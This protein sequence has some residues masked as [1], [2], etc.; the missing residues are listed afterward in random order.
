MNEAKIQNFLLTFTPP[1]QRIFGMVLYAASATHYR[2]K[3]AIFGQALDQQ[4]QT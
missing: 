3:P 1:Y 4:H 2:L